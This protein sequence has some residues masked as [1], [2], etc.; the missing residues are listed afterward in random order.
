MIGTT[1]KEKH[2]KEKKK[3]TFLACSCPITNLSSPLQIS[4]GVGKLLPK[5]EPPQH[6]SLELDSNPPPEPGL[7]PPPPPP[8]RTKF[9][10]GPARTTIPSPDH[11]SGGSPCEERTLLHLLLHNFR[12]QFL[13]LFLLVFWATLGRSKICEPF[14]T[15]LPPSATGLN[16]VKW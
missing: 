4:L 13:S 10:L 11:T 5:L 1:P 2:K 9:E 12:P 8:P 6:S 7:V 3:I 16:E 14:S 15:K